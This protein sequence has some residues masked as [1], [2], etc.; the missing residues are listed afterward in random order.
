MAHRIGFDNE[1]YIELQTARIRE[2]IDAVGGKLYLEF[3]GKLIFKEE[4]EKAL[5][6]AVRTGN[7]ERVERLNE[8]INRFIK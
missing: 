7:Y 1:K 4:M 2:R 8:S 5:D 6:E 3:G